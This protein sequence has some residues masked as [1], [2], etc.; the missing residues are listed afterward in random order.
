MK[1]LIVGSGAVAQ[2][3]GLR[4]QAAGVELGF[5]ARPE[6]AD[7]LKRALQHGGLPLYQTSHFRK[8]NPIAHRLANYQVVTD[9][10]GSQE[11]NP[12]Q[13]WFTTPSTV[14][15]T[16]WFQEFMDKVPAETVVCFAPEGGRE[17]F[18]SQI[19]NQDRLVFGG[20]TFIA[21]QGGTDRGGGQPDGIIFW[22]PPMIEIPLLG[23]ATACRE[24]AELLKTGG[25][26]ASIKNPNFHQSQAAVTGVMTAF[27]AGLELSG[28]SFKAFRRG[29]WLKHAAG[30]AQEGA[31]SQLSKTGF[32]M[33]T[34]L[35]IIFSSFMFYLATFLLPLLFPFDLK[36]YMKFHY[37]KTSEQ[38]LSLLNIFIKDGERRGISVKN[39]QTLLQGLPDSP[40]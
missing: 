34:L 40:D 24:V 28:W 6:S 9:V 15:Y 32:V 35:G 3:F 11:F 14:Y 19:V 25:F 8:R 26:R 20:I 38:S 12:D 37:T 18:I 36:K 17:E 39:L 30:G 10:A 7:R 1:V 27:V 33:R 4:L 2:V 23:S 29:L 21:W 5:Y 31:L 16:K 22:L 13:I